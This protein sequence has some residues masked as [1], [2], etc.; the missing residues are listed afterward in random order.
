MAL[1]V[2]IIDRCGPNNEMHRQLQPKKIKLSYISCLY[3][4][5]RCLPVHKMERFS[6]KKV[7]VVR[8]E[9]NKVHRY[10]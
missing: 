9:Y 4:S 10:L 8:V 3:S 2:D 7:G 1:A 5:K 6:F